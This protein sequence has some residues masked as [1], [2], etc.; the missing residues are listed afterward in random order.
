[1]DPD[2]ADLLDF[3]KRSNKLNGLVTKLDSLFSKVQHDLKKVY[4]I[5]KSKEKQNRSASD[6]LDSLSTENDSISSSQLYNLKTTL[7][8]Y[9][10]IGVEWLCSL[11]IHGVNGIIA[12]EMGLG[13]TL[14]VIAFFQLLFERF[15]N[16]GPHIVVAPL[17]VLSGWESEIST[18]VG[19][20][21]FVY[22]HY[23]EKS[24]RESDLRVF[25]KYVRECLGG[26][27]SFQW[28]SVVI[29]TTY[30]IVIK[31]VHLLKM[32]CNGSSKLQ[33]LVID[34]AHRLKNRESILYRALTQLNI[35]RRILL[36]GTPLQNNIHELWSLLSFI[37]PH[38]FNEEEEWYD[39]F[40]LPFE[41]DDETSQQQNSGEKINFMNDHSFLSYQLT[42]S[43]RGG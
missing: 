4:S 8:D 5:Q 22:K 24:Q 9:Q 18:F 27:R 34:E 13:K 35:S 42:F 19:N 29:L 15:E 17:S 2:E 32:L 39:W 10:K 1:M 7:R 38:F 28:N 30:Q 26:K 16:R 37:L 43:F 40:N 31:D 33:Y 14:Q 11:H 23:G 36:T 3:R 12:D 20:Q 6:D 21:I 41:A 25:Y